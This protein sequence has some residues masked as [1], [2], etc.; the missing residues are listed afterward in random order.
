[1][2]R[3][4]IGKKITNLEGKPITDNFKEG[5][6]KEVYV[7]DLMKQYV[8]QLF[9]AENKERSLL[10]YLTAEKLHKAKDTVELENAEFKILAD[11]LEKPKHNPVIMAPL[12][13]AM[14]EAEDLDKAVTKG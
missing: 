6:D 9:Q 11:S 10:A 13:Q 2:K 7:K 1:M 3:I 14:D 12:Y 5:D 8:G 4:R